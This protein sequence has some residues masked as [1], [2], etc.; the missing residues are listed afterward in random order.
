MKYLKKIIKFPFELLGFHTNR[1]IVV[2]ESDD[3][4]SI[5]MP[6]R[7]VYEKCL[8]AGYPVDLNPFERYDSLA[9]KDDL[10]LL[11]DLLSAYKDIHGRHPIVTANCVVANPDFDKIKADNFQNYHYELINDTFKKYT[12]HS[13]NL[14]IWLH[15]KSE[16]L[17]FPQYHARE[18]LNVSKFMHALQN[19]DTDM[20]FAFDNRMPGTLRKGRVRN[21]NYYV[22]ATHYSDENDKNEK[23]IIYLE[24]LELFEKIF[25]YRSECVTPTNYTW[26]SDY[27]KY[28]SEV[29]IKYIQ[30][31]RKMKEP[32]NSEANYRNRYLGKINEFN[33]IDLVRNCDFEP[34]VQNETDCVEACLSDIKSSFLL[35]K[36]AIICSHRINYV[37]DIDINN[38]DRNLKSLDRI[39]KIALQKWPDIEF[40][41]SVELG[42]LIM[43]N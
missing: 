16:G 6:S 26:S 13:N 15:A 7:E 17:F 3:W 37:G 5:R 9:S 24:G 33:Q 1:K 28:M 38:R 43:N 11:F 40:L 27:N 12:N 35:N 10:D 20:H 34:T 2:I 36:P 19:N 21:G 22:E 31:V 23:R 25:G 18:H 42:E 30:G 29:G 4:G 32:K 39:L 8:K 41:T 14:Q